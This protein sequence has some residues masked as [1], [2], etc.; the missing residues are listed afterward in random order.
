MASLLLE[1][2]KS[3]ADCGVAVAFF[4]CDYKDKSTHEPSNILGS[5]ARQIISQSEEAFADLLEFYQDHYSKDHN[6]Q[7]ATPE[8]LGELIRKTSTYFKT[9]M[10]VVDGLDEIAESRADVTKLLANLNCFDT[11]I[12]TLFASRP[13]VDIEYKLKTYIDLSIKAKGSDLKLYVAFEI[14]TRGAEGRLQIRD[15]TLKSHIMKILVG[16]AEG[17]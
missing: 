16:K 9:T 4:Y 12:K 8:Q 13:E 14:E 11:S 15:P 5:I 7:N 6:L 17:M 10:I 2:Q 1:K 3:D